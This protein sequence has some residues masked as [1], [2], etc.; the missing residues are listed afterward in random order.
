LLSCASPDLVP[1]TPDFSS[2][3]QPSPSWTKLVCDGVEL[4]NS[5]EW[6]D[7]LDEPVQVWLC[8]AC[9][10]THCAAGGCVRITRLGSN[11]LWTRPLSPPEWGSGS[12]FAMHHPLEQLG[13]VLIPTSAWNEWR[14]RFAQLPEVTAFPE[15]SRADV[16]QAWIMDAPPIGGRR[17]FRDR[18]SEA[19]ALSVEEAEIEL[20]RTLVAAEPGSV[21]Q[22]QAAMTSLREWFRERPDERVDG[23]INDAEAFDG[24]VYTWYLDVGRVEEWRAVAER[25]GQLTP[26]FGGK[27]VLLPEPV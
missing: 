20:R 12:Q 19:G 1:W 10:T 3:G 24:D 4:C 15:A 9:G 11:L 16:A 26:V 22:A 7:W 21:E 5:L 14:S 23:E 27:W 18:E 25:N 8:D 13:A 6:V 17:G 2:S